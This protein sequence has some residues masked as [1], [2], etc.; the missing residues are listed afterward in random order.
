VEDGEEV[1]DPANTSFVLNTALSTINNKFEHEC[2]DEAVRPLNAYP[3]RQSTDVQVP[4]HKYSIPGL[5]RTK[6]LIHQI[7]ATWFILRRG[8]RDAETITSVAVAMLHIVVTERDV[9][10]LPRSI[11]QGNTL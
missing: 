6:F 7:W 3:I 1:L 5:P 8:V 2:R 10:G 11:V 9:I 4:G